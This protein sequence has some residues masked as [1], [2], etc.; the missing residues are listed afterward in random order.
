M[1][2]YPIATTT[3]GSGGSTGVTF[4]SIPQN[5]THLQ[6]RYSVRGTN[7]GTNDFTY[8]QLNGDGGNNYARHHMQGDGSSA[9]SFGQ[10]GSGIG[11]IWAAQVPFASTTSNVFGSGIIDIL[12]Y[13]NTNKNKTVRSIGGFDANGSGYANLSS[14]VWMNTSAITSI[15]VSYPN[16]AQYTTVSLYGITTSSVTG[17]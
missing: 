11:A 9:I 15:L 5:F 10:T 8:V 13:T 2:M 4:S 3:V 16:Y 1:S 7:S 17:A 6:I 12:D 14:G